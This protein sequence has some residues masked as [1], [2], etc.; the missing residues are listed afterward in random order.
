[1][2]SWQWSTAKPSWPGAV[3][4]FPCPLIARGLPRLGGP[5][6]KPLRHL[7]PAADSG[8]GEPWLSYVPPETWPAYEGGR[9]PQPGPGRAGRAGPAPAP[10]K[11]RPSSPCPAPPRACGASSSGPA[12][13]KPAWRKFSLRQSPSG[14]PG[15]AW[16]GW[17]CAPVW[18]SRQGIWRSPRPTS[19]SW[20]S[21]TGAARSSGRDPR[22]FLWP[23]PVSGWTAPIL[24]WNNGAPICTAS[25]ANP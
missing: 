12:D 22:T 11:K 2:T 20:A 18:A 16:T 15:A 3:A 8:R 21:G 25:S 5:P 23:T 17:P 10:W 19:A 6:G 24:T 13:R 14:T 4:W 7:P 9:N 1:M